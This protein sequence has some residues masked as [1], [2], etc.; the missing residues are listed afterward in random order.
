MLLAIFRTTSQKAN[1]R[2][3][4]FILSFKLKVED[5]LEIW[6]LKIFVEDEVNLCFWKPSFMYLHSYLGGKSSQKYSKSQVSVGKLCKYVRS[7]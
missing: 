1:L 5:I 2:T 3:F 7:Q 6:I 4:K